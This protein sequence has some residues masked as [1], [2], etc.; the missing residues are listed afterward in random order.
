LFRRRQNEKLVLTRLVS[1]HTILF[2]FISAAYFSGR[3]RLYGRIIAVEATES[4]QSIEV[5]IRHL[6][7]VG[8]ILPKQWFDFFMKFSPLAARLAKT[9][10]KHGAEEAKSELLRV[11]IGTFLLG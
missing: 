3:R 8:Q 6:S 4:T 11:R 1:L 10:Q 9:R 2:F 7:P 5:Y